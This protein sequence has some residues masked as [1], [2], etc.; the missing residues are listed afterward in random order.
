MTIKKDELLKRK[1]EN[2]LK[3]CINSFANGT[4]LESKV[5]LS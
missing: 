5:A 3:L 4:L 1:H 2:P